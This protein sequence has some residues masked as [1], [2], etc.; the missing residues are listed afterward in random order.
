MDEMVFCRICACV[1]GGHG[2]GVRGAAAQE[3]WMIWK[4]TAYKVVVGMCRMLHV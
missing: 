3:E 1:A 2:P 4:A